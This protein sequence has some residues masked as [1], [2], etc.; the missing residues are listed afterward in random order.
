M[1][2]LFSLKSPNDV[3]TM[4]TLSRGDDN[5]RSDLQTIAVI[6]CMPCAND[7]NHNSLQIEFL[8]V[9]INF[10]MELMRC[11]L[12]VRFTTTLE[13][14]FSDHL[15]RSRGARKREERSAFK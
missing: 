3:Q 10:N 6:H 7:L 12:E 5:D 2:Y 13:S 9:V 11:P 8:R 14:Q 1:L 4:V 15:L